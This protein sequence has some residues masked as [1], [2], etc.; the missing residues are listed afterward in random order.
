MLQN[1]AALLPSRE[2]L[3]LKVREANGVIM[4]TKQIVH[5]ILA[6]AGG[7]CVQHHDEA[8][9][10]TSQFGC[11]QLVPTASVNGIFPQP[12]LLSRNSRLPA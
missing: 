3:F 9:A 2:C 11:W 7:N 4:Q 12:K 10:A 1:R 6:V 8:V 5:G